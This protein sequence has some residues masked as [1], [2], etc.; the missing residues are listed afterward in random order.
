MMYVTSARVLYFD[1]RPYTLPESLDELQGPTSG[2]L[3]LPERIAWTGRSRYRLD[4]D[5]EA[6][7]AYERILEESQSSR[8][9]RAYVSHALL[10][11]LW[12]HLYLPIRLR[13]TWEQRFPELG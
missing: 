5:R 11:R 1:H 3:V 12:R 2:V 7:V 8:D 13:R 9:L 6:A 4:D 10:I